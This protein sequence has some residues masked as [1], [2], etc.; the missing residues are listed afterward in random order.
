MV[1]P[2]P[3]AQQLVVQDQLADLDSQPGGLVVSVVGRSALQG[4]LTARQEIVT[5]SGE[6]VRDDSEFE[7]DRFQ[8]LA[9]EEPEH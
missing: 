5:T 6:G 8:V 2:A 1:G 4:G 3:L 9:A 7:Q